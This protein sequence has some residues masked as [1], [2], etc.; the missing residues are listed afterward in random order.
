[1]GGMGG[2]GIE[3]SF[4]KEILGSEGSFGKEGSW[5][6]P[7]FFHGAKFSGFTGGIGAAG[8]GAGAGAGST[9]GAFEPEAGLAPGG[10]PM[11]SSGAKGSPIEGGLGG[12]FG[13]PPSIG[14]TTPSKGH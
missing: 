7:G 13:A 9:G 11:L 6:G 1:M 3:G 10:F 14:L 12:N 5:E 4:G 8:T 2:G